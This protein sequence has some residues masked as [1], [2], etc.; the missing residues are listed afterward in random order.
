MKRGVSGLKVFKQ[1]GLEYRDADGSLL[2]VDDPRWMRFG[3][4]ADSWAFRADAYRRP[5]AFF[6]PID[7]NNERW[8]ELSRHPDWSF[9]GPGFP[10]LVDCRKLA[11]ACSLGILKPTLS[12]HTW[13]T[14]PKIYSNWLVGWT[15][16][17][18]ST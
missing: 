17:P 9:F 18:T 4:D 8:E 13:H 10:T 5:Q 7:E 2:K 15:N 12:L 14:A 3:S 11:I 6:E 1:L 16:I